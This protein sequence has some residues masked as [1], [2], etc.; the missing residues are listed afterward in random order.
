MFSVFIHLIFE[1]FLLLKQPLIDLS[2]T[3][4][5]FYQQFLN[6]LQLH[7]A[8]TLLF[9]LSLGFFLRLINQMVQ[10]ATQPRCFF[11]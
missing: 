4:L 6:W 10:I 3:I 8:K 7:Q 9:R 5:I 1:L 2:H 11:L